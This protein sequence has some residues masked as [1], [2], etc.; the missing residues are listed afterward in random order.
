MV[1]SLFYCHNLVRKRG[2]EHGIYTTNL[3]STERICSTVSAEL[4][5]TDGTGSKSTAT[6]EQ[7]RLNLGTRRD[8][9][10]VL[11]HGT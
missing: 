11:S 7:P 5:T 8:R 3:L 2:Q 1:G 10:E 9:S 6:T 4:S